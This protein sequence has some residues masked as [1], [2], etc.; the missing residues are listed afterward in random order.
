MT[1]A[2]W[3]LQ[4]AIHKALSTDPDLLSTIGGD[5]IYDHVPRKATYPYITF[6]QNT[7]QD[8]DADGGHGDEHIVVLNIWSLAPGREEVQTIIAAIRA[9]LHDRDLPLTG[10]RLINLRHE[11]S[12]ARRENDG[13]RF[14]GTIRLRAVTEPSS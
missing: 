6:G 1:S 8:W 2:S 10:Y 9:A 3:A 7:V 12:E 13:E 5:R 14:L 4:S 11:S